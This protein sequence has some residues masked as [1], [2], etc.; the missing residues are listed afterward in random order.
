MEKQVE[1][2]FVKLNQTWQKGEAVAINDATY[3]VKT[4]DNQTF[5]VPKGSDFMEPQK[6]PAQRFAM[7]EAKERLEGAYISFEKL[8]ENVQDAIVKG[9]EH[10]LRTAYIKDGKLNETVKMVQMVYSPTSGSRLDVQIKRKEPVTL[11]KA[12]AYNHQ[13]TKAEF[14]KMVND[15]K[16]IAFTGST[17]DGEMFTKLAYYE[18]KV[19]DIR[20]KAALT[21]NTYLFGQQLTQ[22]QADNMNKGMETKITLRKTKRGPITYMVSYSPRAEKFIT[23]SLE[24]AKL[25]E[26]EVKEA[27][28]VNSEKKKSGLRHAISL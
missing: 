9:E 4:S 12:K 19:N 27:V 16:H 23:R 24:K 22:E 8:P 14:D 5:E 7:G 1:K 10:L 13:F 6:F 17:S 20:T 15:E 28:T 11:D 21:A 25:A 18:P 26:L 2:V 3:K